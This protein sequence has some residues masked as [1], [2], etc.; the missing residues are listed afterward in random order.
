M[1]YKITTTICLLFF[2]LQLYAQQVST[3]ILDL[4]SNKKLHYIHTV[5]FNKVIVYDNR[6]DTSKFRIEETGVT[7]VI[8]IFNRPIPEAIEL[9]IESAIAS[10]PKRDQPIYISINQLRF[11]NMANLSGSLFFSADA[12][13]QS[14]DSLKKIASQTR[15]YSFKGSY[16]KTITHAI[17]KLIE[18]ISNNYY[19]HKTENNNNYT[20]QDIRK[21]VI[22]SWYHYPI[23]SQTPY[24]DGI[25]WSLNDFKNNRTDSSGTTL[26]LEAD[27]T[28]KINN[29]YYSNT[30]INDMFAISYNGNLYKCV[31]GKYFLPIIR[32]DSFFYFTVPS[33]LPNMYTQIAKTMLQPVG[34]YNNEFIYGDNVYATIAVNILGSIIQDAIND[35]KVHNNNKEKIITEDFNNDMRSCFIDMGSGDIIY[36]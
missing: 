10:Y 6:F 30:K 20:I 21:N 22:N 17:N 12:Y 33:T 28:Y 23:A 14:K 19:Q 7:P 32:I 1:K 8:D 34:S 11:G 5:P 2:A 35:N 31:L 13:I 18:E 36:Y 29:R 16:R 15:I 26:Q 3:N 25:Y 24:K 9:Y 27:S 4:N